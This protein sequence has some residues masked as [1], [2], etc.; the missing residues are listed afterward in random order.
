M[1]AGNKNLVRV[2]KLHKPVQEIEN[3]F[4]GAV[5]TEI[6]TMNQNIAIWNA[7]KKMVAAMGV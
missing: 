6:S 2:R 7:L 1:V 3:F 5:V 4:L